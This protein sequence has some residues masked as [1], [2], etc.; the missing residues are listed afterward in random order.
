[1][2]NIPAN[3]RS[4]N[5]SELLAR[6]RNPDAD[7][8][9][10]RASERAAEMTERIAAAQAHSTQVMRDLLQRQFE[11]AAKIAALHRQQ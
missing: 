8:A 1:M 9:I 3:A 4:V 6:R 11:Q 5:M 2:F 7:R 10:R